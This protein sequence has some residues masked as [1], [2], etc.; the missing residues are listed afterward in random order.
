[1]TVAFGKLGDQL[2]DAGHRHGNRPLPVPLLERDRLAERALERQLEIRCH[3]LRLALGALRIAA[4]AR[5][6]PMCLGRKART[7]LVLLVGGLS[8]RSR[9]ESER[10]SLFSFNIS[11]LRD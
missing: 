2:L 5:F 7:D 9:A 8:F 11:V 3:R 1:M 6:E 10:R 4:L